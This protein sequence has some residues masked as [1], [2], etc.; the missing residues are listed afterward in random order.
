MLPMTVPPDPDQYVDQ[1]RSRLPKYPMLPLFAALDT[2]EADSD[3]PKVQWDEIDFVT[4]RN[5]LLKLLQFAEPGLPSLK[6]NSFRIDMQLISPWTILMQGSETA[7]TFNTPPGTTL[8][9]NSFEKESTTAGVSYANSA[10]GSHN[11]VI[12]YV[13]FLYVILFGRSHLESRTLVV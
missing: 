5:S 3:H 2:L 9:T 8:Y 12:S 10:L 4:D 6:A 13:G 7:I 1:H 11:R